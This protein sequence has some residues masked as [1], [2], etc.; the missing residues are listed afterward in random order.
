MSL[1]TRLFS[2]TFKASAVLTQ[3]S[4]TPTSR[5]ETALSELQTWYNE[6]SGLWN[7]CG[8]WNGANCMTMLADLAAI[9]SSVLDTAT[10]VF[11]NTYVVAPAVNP[12]PGV[13]KV[14]IAGMP[15]TSYPP[16]WPDRSS[17]DHDQSQDSANA[18]AW[19]DG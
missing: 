15:Y 14:M 7:T 8:W 9:D 11:N 19:L 5:A 3:N 17:Y 10:Y 6:S 1:L 2:F 16:S 12:D 13:E 4:T 18:S